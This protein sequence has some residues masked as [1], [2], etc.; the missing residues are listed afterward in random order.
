MLVSFIEMRKFI[1]QMNRESEKT[2]GRVDMF[3]NQWI[4][5]IN[6]KKTFE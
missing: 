6:R 1:K 3:R 4:V 5:E 2:L